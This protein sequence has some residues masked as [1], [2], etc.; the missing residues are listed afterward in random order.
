MC[1]ILLTEINK[2]TCNFRRIYTYCAGSAKVV[3]GLQRR[4]REGVQND[5]G[6]A[7]VMQGINGSYIFL[8]KWSNSETKTVKC[9]MVQGL[10]C[11]WAL[12]DLMLLR[13]FPACAMIRDRSVNRKACTI[14]SDLSDNEK[15][16]TTTVPG[17]QRHHGGHLELIPIGMLT[18]VLFGYC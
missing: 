13:P 11:L 17:Q 9:N 6:D 18:T 10:G 5:A 14:T 15:A 16:C 4:E 3:Q 2:L 1:T 12:W 8:T 7:K